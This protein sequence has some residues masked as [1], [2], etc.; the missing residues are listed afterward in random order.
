MS[1][2]RGRKNRNKKVLGMSNTVFFS[3]IIIMI[4]I[5]VICL[6][7]LNKINRSNKQRIATEQD[8]IKN[9]IEEIYEATNKEISE[10]DNYK[11]NTIIRVS[12]I[13]DILCG[14]NLEQ[15]GK[16]YDYIFSDVVKYF[17]DSDINIGTYETDINENKKD[18]ITSIK[19]LGIN[20]ISL[21]NNHALDNGKQG[22]NE[23]NDYLNSQQ[24]NTV[25]ITADTP[26]KRVKIIEIKN[27]KIS[28]LAYTYDNHKE[29][30]NIYDEE[31]IKSDLDYAKNN[32]SISIAI[33]HWGNLNTNKVSEKQKEQAEFL[34]QNG[35]DIIIGSHPSA[36]QEMEIIKNKEGKDCF[37][38][39]SLGNFT[40]DF[41][42]KIADLELILNLEIFVDR[43]G[44][45]SIYKVNYIPIYMTDFGAKLK[46]KRYKILDMKYEIMNYGTNESI[47]DKKIYDKLVEGIEK[48]KNII[49]KD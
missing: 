14:K 17:I 49:K 29:G 40:S 33:M 46:E 31:I 45:A 16:D 39:Y 27:T 8:K 23:I 9:Q 35:A 47:I 11:T 30:V 21:A 4:I 25:G 43:D 3:S 36:V 28:I 48:L 44:N 10:L 2:R 22:L 6:F 7:Y 13:G 20:W 41:N 24:I 38:A 32:S 18:F 34:V 15:Y 37:V 19:N 5:I 42:S 26:E 1:N 12:A